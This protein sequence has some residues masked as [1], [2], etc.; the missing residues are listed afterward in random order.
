MV[1]SFIINDNKRTRA[2]TAQLGGD[3]LLL[4]TLYTIRWKNLITRSEDKVKDC[5]CLLLLVLENGEDMVRYT[6][7]RVLRFLG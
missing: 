3:A 6:N 5:I 2:S 1:V 7:V 4:A